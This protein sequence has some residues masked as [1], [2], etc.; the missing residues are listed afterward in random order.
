MS[1]LK[2]CP[3]CGVRDLSIIKKQV[4]ITSYAIKCEPCGISTT[5]YDNL[6]NAIEAWNQRAEDSLREGLE[7]IMDELNAS[8][9]SSREQYIEEDDSFANGEYAAYDHATNV[10]KHLL[11]KSNDKN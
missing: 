6:S 8:L 3:F 2:R 10:L 11:E 9:K 5:Y 4:G 1:E 7:K